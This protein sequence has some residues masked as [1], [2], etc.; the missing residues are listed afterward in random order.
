MA[1][2]Y[3]FN[4]FNLMQFQTEVKG[5]FISKMIR[6]SELPKYKTGYFQ[7]LDYNV[8]HQ[9][10]GGDY[11]AAI[12]KNIN[13]QRKYILADYN[14]ANGGMAF[15]SHQ[16]DSESL[17]RLCSKKYV[18]IHCDYFQY[19][20]RSLVLLACTIASRLELVKNQIRKIKNLPQDVVNIILKYL[21]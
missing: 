12:V 20:S 2:K 19:D 8:N 5:D 7:V 17:L 9:G 14:A 4:D 15:Y 3:G 16:R 11:R 1:A 6:E 10:A 18:W 21:K 13:T